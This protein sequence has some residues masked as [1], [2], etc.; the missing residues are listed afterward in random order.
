MGAQ[1]VGVGE[2]YRTYDLS[3]GHWGLATGCVCLKG[4]GKVESYYYEG[5]DIGERKH[6]KRKAFI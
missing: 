4:T 1:A 5:V 6:E 3:S 2:D